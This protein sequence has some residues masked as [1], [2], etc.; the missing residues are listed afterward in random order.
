MGSLVA[1]TITLDDVKT[2]FKGEHWHTNVHEDGSFEGNSRSYHVILKASDEPEFAVK[3]QAYEDESDKDEAVTDEPMKFLVDFLKTG[4]AGDQAM[5]QMAGV[6][7]REANASPQGLS[8]VLRH[9]ADNVQAER[10][11]PQV[12][13]RLL[14]RASLLPDMPTTMTVLATAILAARVA[15]REDIET[16]EMQELANNMTKK[17]WRVK[18]DK[19]DRG[20][21]E[22][23]VDIAGV[24]EAKIEVDNIPWKYLFEVHEHPD[25]KA[26]G[27]TDDP[28]A[29]FR[30]YYRSDKVQDAKAELKTISVPEEGTRPAAPSSKKKE[31]PSEPS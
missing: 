10:I 31:Q 3:V 29:E 17:G 6:F 25:T 19:N 27:V 13:A 9:W 12:L 8:R 23:T 11:E 14:R 4:T 1:A 24:Y 22:L 30:R 26:E 5:Q 16:K 20:L 7:Q 21:P 28:I 15:A 18:A 2:Y